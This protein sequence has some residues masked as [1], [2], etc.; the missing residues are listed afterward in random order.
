[1]RALPG[2]GDEKARILVA[3]LAKRQGVRPAGWERAAG[4]FA[5]AT[6]RSV[7]DIHD[8]E[9]LATVRRWKQAQKARKLDKQDRPL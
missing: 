1:M 5:D 3:L 8:P 7:A 9:S 6:P 4:A 2:F